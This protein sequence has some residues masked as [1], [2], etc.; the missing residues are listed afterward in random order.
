MEF[1]LAE[2]TLTHLVVSDANLL[3]NFLLKTF[4][5]HKLWSSFQIIECIFKVFVLSEQSCS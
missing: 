4:L 1:S 5:N 3:L 2:Q